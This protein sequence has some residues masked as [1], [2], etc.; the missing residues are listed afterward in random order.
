MFLGRSRLSERHLVGQ[1]ASGFLSPGLDFM[2][3]RTLYNTMVGG[4]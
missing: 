1:G 4:H 2:A 3:D